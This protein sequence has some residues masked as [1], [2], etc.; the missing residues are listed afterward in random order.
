[1]AQITRAQAIQDVRRRLAEQREV[2]TL[3]LSHLRGL[4]A[5]LAALESGNP[6][7]TPLD[8]MSRTD[9]IVEILRRSERHLRP[10]EVRDA[11]NSDGWDDELKTVTATLRYL[12]QNG[13]VVRTDSKYTAL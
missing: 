12:V 7:Q 4:E 8:A 11:L 13:R 5:E 1:M 6:P 9:A 10:I 3:A 2:V